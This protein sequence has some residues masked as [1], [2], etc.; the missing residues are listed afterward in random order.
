MVP[1]PA[2]R[3]TETWP[4]ILTGVPLLLVVAGVGVRA[5]EVGDVDDAGDGSEA[6]D[7]VEVMA[8]DY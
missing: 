7:A 3:P 2:T 8:A 1:P 5:A 4:L 6:Q